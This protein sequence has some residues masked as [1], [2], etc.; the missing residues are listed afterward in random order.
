MNNAN[1]HQ[2]NF[3]L[4][5]MRQLRLEN[6][7]M[8]RAVYALLDTNLKTKEVK[9]EGDETASN[10][11]LT[12]KDDI[13]T[14]FKSYLNDNQLAD[15]SLA[16]STFITKREEIG[17]YYPP[18]KLSSNN[19][20]NICARL[21]IPFYMVFCQDFGDHRN[22]IYMRH[23]Y[24]F[25]ASDIMKLYAT[26][27]K[28]KEIHWLLKQQPA[29][30]QTGDSEFQ[31][32]P[33]KEE[34]FDPK[35]PHDYW[36]TN[37]NPDEKEN[38]P[39]GQDYN[40]P[41]SVQSC[42]TERALAKEE[43]SIVA[44]DANEKTG[45]D[46][47]KTLA[48]FIEFTDQRKYSL[49]MRV[50]A[51]K[52][53]FQVH[54][55]QLNLTLID[56]GFEDLLKHILQN[57]SSFT[58]KE[59]RL[60][61]LQNFVRPKG[62]SLKNAI[63]S[64]SFLFKKYHDLPE[65]A[66]FGP[67]LEKNKKDYSQSLHT[68]VIS[69]VRQLVAP[70]LLPTFET[71]LKSA[72][73][74]NMPTNLMQ[75]IHLLDKDEEIHNCQ[76]STDMKLSVDNAIM[77]NNLNMKSNSDA[78]DQPALVNKILDEDE[79]YIHEKR[80]SQQ[81]EFAKGYQYHAYATGDKPYPAVNQYPTTHAYPYAVSM[82]GN[83]NPYTKV[84][85]EKKAS[86]LNFSKPP[87]LPPPSNG[88]KELKAIQNTDATGNKEFI[89]QQQLAKALQQ[90]L[91]G[92]SGETLLPFIA[93]TPVDQAGQVA[94]TDGTQQPPASG[95]ASKSP[96]GTIQ[97]T[98][99]S[100]EDAKAQ[101]AIAVKGDANN[102]PST[103][104]KNSDDITVGPNNRIPS[105][106]LTID[107]II[108][109]NPYLSSGLPYTSLKDIGENFEIMKRKCDAGDGYASTG[110]KKV[111]P[112]ADFDITEAFELSNKLS[113]EEINAWMSYMGDT[114]SKNLNIKGNTRD[115]LTSEDGIRKFNMSLPIHIPPVLNAAAILHKSTFL[116]AFIRDYYLWV[117][118]NIV[119]SP[120]DK[121]LFDFNT[122][123]SVVLDKNG[124]PIGGYKKLEDIYTNAT[125][126]LYNYI[127]SI[128][129][130]EPRKSL[131]QQRYRNPSQS[132]S[133]S[134]DRRRKSSSY[135]RAKRKFDKAYKERKGSKYSRDSS[136]DSSRDSSLNSR[137]RERRTRSSSYSRRDKRRRSNSYRRNDRRRSYDRSRRGRSYDRDRRS[138]RPRSYE[139]TRSYDSERRRGNDRRSSQDRRRSYSR[140]RYSRRD[141]SRDRTRSGSRDSKS[142]S[143]KNDRRRSFSSENRE[144]SSSNSNLRTVN[145][146]LSCNEGVNCNGV[147]TSKCLKCLRDHHTHRCP[148]YYLLAKNDCTNCPKQL[149]YYSECQK[150]RKRKSFP[151]SE[152]S[153][154]KPKN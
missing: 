75:I 127:S 128:D 146:N 85:S 86:G 122:F 33:V 82:P 64:V 141:R 18:G 130:D 13:L 121:V 152:D 91:I 106:R 76:P 99:P 36:P 69:A 9:E 40:E 140:D 28:D 107:Q 96:E 71:F 153:Y 73:Y 17:P 80:E 48:N 63:T 55:P 16:D 143:Y 53:I 118:T 30:Y 60:R 8:K 10:K 6:D 148:Y 67:K 5:E 37:K 88:T 101:E 1:H 35:N 105:E 26:H 56:Q 125:V 126:L 151:P 74:A 94:P 31:V 119:N 38:I 51:L 135:E 25:K 104:A 116:G 109:Q 27:Q 19:V 111:M 41:V 145:T 2:T 90:P 23:F 24:K 52:E 22:G 29:P 58:E 133:V 120:T 149:H 68:F 47:I 34:P 142:G 7:M 112:H 138:N 79:N 123:K 115:T 46:I 12:D 39:Y 95:S 4:V 70:Q 87:P 84:D 144:R 97:S 89:T 147:H 21:G 50:H 77:I 136:N 57:T 72:Q 32:L 154:T 49:N 93:Q 83:Y 134:F 42:T 114:F 103:T 61:K 15:N 43:L 11:V 78:K 66:H 92:A 3:E 62:T 108:A 44:V 81:E 139:R 14:N 98:P 20:K 113:N 65:A 100:N 59:I 124:K 131:S 129:R 150:L 132:P 110:C 117:K 54:V 137:S 45:I 102:Q